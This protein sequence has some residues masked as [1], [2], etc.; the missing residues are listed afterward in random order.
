[1]SVPDGT[2]AMLLIELDGPSVAVQRDAELVMEIC[3]SHNAFEIEKAETEEEKDSLWAI[4]RS[5]S[6]ALYAISS[7]KVNEDI[8]VPRSKLTEMLEKLAEIG[9]KYSFTIAN[10]GHAGDGNIHVNILTDPSVPGE[11]ERAEKAVEEIFQTVVQLGG[12]LSGEHG[13]GNTKSKYLKYEVGPVELK[14]MREIKKLFDPNNILNPGKIFYDNIFYD[15][16]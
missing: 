7:G 4:R 11:L 3:R 15:N 6:P 9:E 13:I 10:F 1:F 16:K 14:L 2:K 5:I 12:T 8:C